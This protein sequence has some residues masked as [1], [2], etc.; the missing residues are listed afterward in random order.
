MSTSIFGRFEFSKFDGVTATGLKPADEFRIGAGGPNPNQALLDRSLPSSGDV[1]VGEFVQI[2][3]SPHDSA[4]PGPE[5]PPDGPSPSKAA[6]PAELVVQSDNSDAGNDTTSASERSQSTAAAFDSATDSLQSAAPLFPQP[7][8]DVERYAFASDQSAFVFSSVGNDHPLNLHLTPNGAA[9]ETVVASKAFFDLGH[10]VVVIQTSVDLSAYFPAHPSVPPAQPGP[11]ANAPVSPQAMLSVSA[12]SAA[13]AVG[14]AAAAPETSAALT[15]QSAENSALSA[16]LTSFMDS[17]STS[18]YPYNTVVLIETKFA[19]DPNPNEFFTGTGVI[20]GPHTIL[21]AAHMLWDT[22][23]NSEATSVYIYPAYSA[24]G[25]P[26]PAGTGALNTNETWHN[27]KVGNADG[28]ISDS[29]SQ[30]DFGIIDVGYTFTSYMGV[31]SDWAGGTAHLTGYPNTAGGLQTDQVG[32]VTKDPTYSILDYGSIVSNHGNSGGPLWIDNGSAGSVNPFVV[33]IASSSASSG[34]IT[35]SIYQQIQTWQSSD[36]VTP[37]GTKVNHA[38]VV[39]IPSANVTMK[40]GQTIA[41]S[42][43]FSASDQDGDPL[44]YSFYNSTTGPSA[45]Y[46]AVNGTPQPNGIVFSVSASQLSQVTFVAG[47]AN[48]SDSLH[49]MAYDGQA[50]SGGNTFAGLT[51]TIPLNHA[52]VVTPFSGVSAGFGQSIIATNL[53]SASD[54]DGDP[55]TYYLVNTTTGPTAGF[56]TVNGVVQPNNNVFAV[57]AADLAHTFFVTGTPG[58]SDDVRMIAFDGQA[59]S[60]GGVFSANHITVAPDHAPVVTALSANVSTKF[61]QSTSASSLFSASDADGNALTYFLYNATQGATAGYFTVN[62]VVQPNG[63]VFAVGAAQL[64]Q[65]Y[66]V[67]GTPGSSNNLRMMAYDGFLYSGNSTFTGTSVN[68]LPDNPPVVTIPSAN[69]SATHGQSIAASSLFSASDADGNSLVYFLENGTKGATAGYFTVN[70]VVQPN[71]I[72]F[73]VNATDLAHTTFVAGGP[74]SSNDLHVMAYDGYLYSGNT[75]F[76]GVNV[77][78]SPNHPPV[79][80]APNANYAAF[81][82]QT[83]SVSSLFSVSDQDSGDHMTYF[84]YDATPASSG[85]GHWSVNGT[86]IANQTVVALNPSEFA[87]ATFVAGSGGS[88]DAISVLAFDGYAYSNGGNFTTMH[89]NVAEHAPVVSANTSNYAASAG[90]SVAASSL[91]SSSDQDGDALTY[92]V[93]DA[94]PAGAGSGHW[95]VNGTAIANQT[96]VALSA[97]QFSQ[98][99]FVAGGGGSSDAVSV[100]AYDGHLY[101]NNGNFTTTHVS[102]A[103]HAPVVTVSSAN[104]FA[105]AGQGFAALSLFSASDA[106][107][108]PLT[109]FLTDSTPS[110]GHWTVNGNTI[111][112]QTVVALTAADLAQTSFVAGPPG[113]NDDLAVMVYDGHAYSNGTT[114]THFHVLV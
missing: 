113:S 39:T 90:Q 92:F 82:K 31:I 17:Y 7:N 103:N 3:S 114:F 12:N 100:M 8:S 21:T 34:Q 95:S 35:S 61:G 97:T 49:V 56:F 104:V 48:S 78:V 99:T 71:G 105:N 102:V 108:D 38:P 40:P 53:F 77:N 89:V 52:P 83:I 67:S 15:G 37:L 46:F 107:H 81:G 26:N 68:V 75:S 110:G 85:A 2:T 45:G 28:T 93:Y 111:A 70:G 11:T 57:G 112:A 54:Q 44:T 22:A 1:Q 72:V 65:T 18:T 6:G 50:Y 33:G 91:F 25:Y 101:S 64:A 14:S 69:V 19:N 59:Y 41:A 29:D 4:T 5:L 80:T 58:S 76:A 96:V 109:Y 74:G 30:F 36:G 51:V 55:L 47:A 20:I 88:S 10:D 66:F 60:N 87:S 63:V 16:A 32:S 23:F 9:S 84:L 98:T 42:S 73:T 43:L 13:P 94:T 86:A 106:D 79:V 62:G 27:Y 24:N